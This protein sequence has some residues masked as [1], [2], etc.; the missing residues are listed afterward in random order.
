MPRP[1]SLVWTRIVE[2][3]R[4]PEAHLIPRLAGEHPDH[5]PKSLR[6]APW[7]WTGGSP[8]HGPAV[9]GIDGTTMAVS[10]AIYIRLIGP[11]PP[12][13]HLKAHT[14]LVD[15]NPLHYTL[16]GQ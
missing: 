8:R 5:W 15:V 1:R 7:L 14:N 4:H 2:N 10:R 13:R 12:N 11:L 6:D 9:I 16:T 3:I